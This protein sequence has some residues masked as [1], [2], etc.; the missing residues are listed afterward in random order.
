MAADFDFDRRF[1]GIGRLHGAAT[2]ERYRAAHVCVVGI[3]GVGS[4]T[5]EAL[6]RSGVGRLTLIDLDHVAESNINRQA[7]AVEENLGKAKVTAMAER[8]R[9]INPACEV[10]EIEEFVTP[11]NAA[12]LLAGGFD[13]VVDAIDQVRA[14]VAMIADCREH[15]LPIV[16]AGGAGGKSDPCRIRID[17]LSR[18]EQDPLLSKV[19]A[20]LRRAHG[21]SRDPRKR[22]GVAAV[23][24]TEPVQQPIAAACDVPEEGTVI[25]AGGLNCAGFGSSMC[26]TA[27]FG[28]FAAAAALQ[29]LGEAR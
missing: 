28:L 4:W 9:S 2:L 23:Y 13:V 20:Q 14:K 11:E 17:D 18:T 8:I 7:H 19:R 5:V 1:G 21:F 15:G 27:S 24:S 16:V 10:N 12:T 25:G 6:A 3:G 26:I 29:T 22:F